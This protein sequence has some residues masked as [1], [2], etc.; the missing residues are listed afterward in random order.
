MIH[1]GRVFKSSLETVYVVLYAKKIFPE[2]KG[3]QDVILLSSFNGQVFHVQL[4]L[5]LYDCL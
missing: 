2:Y 5:D 1:V 4:C 3:V